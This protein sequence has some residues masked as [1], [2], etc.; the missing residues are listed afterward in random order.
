[1]LYLYKSTYFKAKIFRSEAHITL[2]ERRR[3]DNGKDRFNNREDSEVIYIKRRGGSRKN[4]K[5]YIRNEKTLQTRYIAY[6]KDSAYWRN[7]KYFQI[8]KKRSPLSAFDSLARSPIYDLQNTFFERLNIV[9]Y[10]RIRFDE[11]IFFNTTVIDLR[12]FLSN[13][14]FRISILMQFIYNF[15]DVN[16][17]CK[18]LMLTVIYTA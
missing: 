5:I 15:D 16:I 6:R 9:K 10:I 11:R 1:V 14:S 13:S 4:R 17:L 8:Y 2:T 18:R 7:S 12:H 3:K